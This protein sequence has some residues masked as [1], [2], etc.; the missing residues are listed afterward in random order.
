M[1][2][3]GLRRG[4]RGS[5]PRYAATIEGVE[6]EA[7]ATYPIASPTLLITHPDR[8]RGHG[9]AGVLAERLVADGRAAGFEIVP[10]CPFINA[11]PRKHSE[12]TVVLA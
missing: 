3:L 7:E 10:L 5:E 11:E 8:M 12:W 1:S 6:G 2:D 4:M 9:V